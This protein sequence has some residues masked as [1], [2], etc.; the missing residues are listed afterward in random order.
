MYDAFVLAAGLGTRLRPL[1]AH[2]PKPLVPVCGV[3]MLAYSL[4]LCAKHDLRR[5]VVNAHW[6]WE[7]IAAWE[8]DHEGVR[9]AVAVELPEILG[10]GGGLR[11]VRHD[12]KPRFVVVN[13]DVINDV[14]LTRLIGAVPPGGAAM[15]LRS[16]AEASRYG[17]VAADAAGRVAELV[18]VAKSEPEGAVERSTHFTGIHAMDR[19]ALELVPDGFACIV[20]TAYRRLVPERKVAAIRHPG[21]WL[22]IGDVP[23]YLEANLAVLDGGLRLPLD[24]F[25]RAAWARTASGEHGNSRTIA[26]ITVEGPAWI[27]PAANLGYGSRLK[28]TIVGAGARIP[29]GTVLEDC[30]VWDGVDVPEGIHRGA[31]VHPGGVLFPRLAAAETDADTD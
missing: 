24:P 29:P 22:D 2:R 13:A 14:D 3:P 4:A 20:R 11:A 7:Q 17:I 27:G 10:T 30:V 21:V 31:V 6:L 16:D 28:R 1:T 8:G 25:E 18:Q 15:A 26:G 9:V 19:E 5:V 12:L 23:A